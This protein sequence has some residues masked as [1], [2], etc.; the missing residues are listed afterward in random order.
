[1]ENNDESINKCLL[2]VSR[3]IGEL[4]LNGNS[5]QLNEF[6][7]WIK[8]H[9]QRI[10]L[11]RGKDEKIIIRNLDN[12][13]I[14]EDAL[15]IFDADLNIIRYSGSQNF[16]SNSAKESNNLLHLIYEDDHAKLKELISQAIV[17]RKDFRVDLRI[18]SNINILNHCTLEIDMAASNPDNNRFIAS[19]KFS[20]MLAAHLL[21]Y[22]ALM[23]DNL[24]GMDIYLFDANYTYLFA[25]GKEKVR[26]DLHNEQ[27]I[28]QSLFKVLEKKVVRL[29]Y[30]YIAKALQGTENEGEIRYYNE[31]YYLKATPIK[32]FNN[33]TV[34]AILF[35]QNIT[36]DKVLEEQLKYSKEEA[37]KADRLKSIFIANVSHEI[38]TPLSAIMGFT[39]QLQKTSLADEQVKYVKLIN[40]ASDHL[41]YLVTEIVFLFKLGMGKI[42]LEKSAFSLLDLL[43][44]LNETFQGQALEKNLSFEIKYPEIFPDVLVGDSFRLRQILM[45]LLVNA[46][47]YTESGSIVMNCK[48][49]KDLKK[50]IDLVF[51]IE[52]TGIGISKS[53]LQNIFNVFEQGDKFNASF[54]G[55]AGLGLG[56]CKNLVEL[57]NGNISVTSKLNVGST[58]TVHLTFDKTSGLLQHIPKDYKYSL[59]E[60]DKLLVDKKILLADDDEHSLI[61]ADNILKSW[62]T[63]YKLVDDGQKA[64]DLLAKNK[65]DI[66]LIDIHMP[67]K[68]GLDVIKFVRSDKIGVNYTTP[69]IFMT[70]NALRTDLNSYIKVGF[71]DY[72]IKPFREIE[73]Y[74]K[75]CNTLGIKSTRKTKMIIAEPANL[76]EVK[77]DFFNAKELWKT[78]NG[79]SAFFENM[80]NNFISTA[81]SVKMI[82]SNGVSL[83]NWN[84]IGEKAHKTIPSFKYF[85]LHNLVGLLEIVEEKTL[86][87]IDY[88]NVGKII[89]K[90][91]VQIDDILDQAKATLRKN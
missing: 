9:Y 88:D 80:I 86:R 51:K 64:I 30:P 10:Q 83:G 72:L 14:R 5:R 8:T 35:S 11:Q 27:M 73:L 84:E 31:T 25:A 40:K 26:F 28:G 53:N 85:G 21:E 29:V 16:F 15:F 70:A 41:L 52:D 17:N 33:E 56:I 58:F 67:V 39:E 7:Y 3:K 59:E 23:L 38:R 69:I 48:V 71:D 55:G 65:Y 60:N 82:F 32:N 36:S 87:K 45:N 90:I 68:S 66:V 77:N 50:R 81:A 54:R 78:A 19:L 76:E 13:E 12:Q 43:T 44:D 49:K 89:E 57:L 1:M 24:P 79:N 4:L 2:E 47:K 91:L 42:Y 18:K 6:E 46:I 75:L 63:D 61:L 22:Q 37:L 62:Q 20:E 34:A 74:S